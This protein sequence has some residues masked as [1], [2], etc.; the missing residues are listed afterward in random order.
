[1]SFSEQ[2]LQNE[3]SRSVSSKLLTQQE[4]E[5]IFSMVG[6]QCEV[7]AIA[8]VQVYLALPYSPS[9]WTKKCCGVACFV[10]DNRNL[11]YDIRVYNIQKR[12]VQLEQDVHRRFRYNTPKQFFHTFAMED[13]QAAFNFA[14]ISEALRFKNATHDAIW[15]LIN[16]IQATA[17]LPPRLPP[18]GEVTGTLQEAVRTAVKTASR[19]NGGENS[20]HLTNAV[21]NTRDTTTNNSLSRN[22]SFTK[23]SPT[24]YLMTEITFLNC[25]K[26]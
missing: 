5:Q 16:R 2:R 19:E 13:C 12:M 1:M 18:R 7:Y 25:T 26:F 14:D 15:R 8:V 11:L 20:T 24:H 4:N 17:Q 10:R 6:Q 21:G 22:K 9:R 23:R 3:F